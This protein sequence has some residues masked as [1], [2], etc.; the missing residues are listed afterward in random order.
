MGCFG[1]L[2]DASWGLFWSLELRFVPPK[3]A[4]RP[5]KT[6]ASLKENNV[7]EL[8]AYVGPSWRYVGLCRLMSAYV[9]LGLLAQFGKTECV[10]TF[11]HG[12][13]CKLTQNRSNQTRDIAFL[14]CEFSQRL[15]T[16]TFPTTQQS[17]ETAMFAYFC[18]TSQAILRCC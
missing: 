14:K 1:V 4:L 2:L 12:R 15:Q 11:S 8:P 7:F 9:G 3:L 10:L 18:N 13:Y 17:H 16:T 5:S 6:L